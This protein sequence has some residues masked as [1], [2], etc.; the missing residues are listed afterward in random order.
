MHQFFSQAIAS[1]AFNVKNLLSALFSRKAG[2]AIVAI[3]L[4]FVSTGCNPSAPN[5][6][7]NSGSYTERKGQQTEL[8]DGVQP[9]TGGMNQHNDDF[10]Y[11]R[12]AT[13][14]KTDQMIRQADRN[15]DK[16]KTPKDAVNELKN[17]NPGD[18][19]RRNAEAAKNTV[20]KVTNDISEGAKRG[21]EN[22]K[23][24]AKKAERN[25]TG[26]GNDVAD[27]AQRAG[28]GAL[29]TTQRAIDDAIDR[30]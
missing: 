4:L 15:L 9:A 24:N 16:T 28:E 13:Q 17:A 20:G 21:T 2:V 30:T 7:G 25:V 26:F 5:V 12:G 19:I 1:I 22:L 23:A 14:G 27:K 18:N 29:N 10:R 8:Y 6:V 11:D 3:A